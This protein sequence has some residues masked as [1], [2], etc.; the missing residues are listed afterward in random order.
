MKTP[1]KLALKRNTNIYYAR[2][3]NEWLD[4]LLKIDEITI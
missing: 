3:L 4:G 2:K 1:L